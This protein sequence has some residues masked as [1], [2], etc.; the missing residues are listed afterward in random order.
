MG[1]V[2][3]RCRGGGC[4]TDKDLYFISVGLHDFDAIYLVKEETALKER[5]LL[6]NSHLAPFG[7]CVCNFVFFPYRSRGC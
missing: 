7:I 1:G 2:W 4:K 3:E 6:L 5:D